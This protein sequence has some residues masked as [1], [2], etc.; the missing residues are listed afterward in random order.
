MSYL[1]LSNYFLTTLQNYQK[2]ITPDN[3]LV[4]ELNVDQSDPL[5]RIQASSPEKMIL[6]DMST[7]DS[8]DEMSGGNYIEYTDTVRLHLWI[9]IY[10]QSINN[11]N[12]AT[13]LESL[14]QYVI[15]AMQTRARQV[16]L[17][18]VKLKSAAK[19]TI[20]DNYASDD[21]LF[22]CVHLETATI[23]V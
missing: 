18:K 20:M 11:N 15:A 2:N 5:S 9:N 14:R 17:L 22:E 21:M 4:I 23:A 8:A 19:P 16:G 13:L 12:A 6:I 3:D 1:D 7:T 10:T